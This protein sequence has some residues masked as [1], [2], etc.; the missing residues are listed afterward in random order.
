L[1]AIATTLLI[2][3]KIL[4]P[5]GA[6]GLLD[7]ARLNTRVSD[8]EDTLLTLV[9]APGGFGKTTLAQAWSEALAQRGN[10]IAWLSLDPD[11]DEPQ[12]FLHYAVHAFH[13]AHPDVGAASLAMFSESA[14]AQ[15]VHA[16]SLLINEIAGC[17]E[18]IFF[19]LDD[20]Q[21]IT[22]P[23]IH[24]LVS[25]M[26]RYAPSNLHL[27]ILSREDAPLATASLRVRNKLLEIDAAQLRF[28]AEETRLFFSRSNVTALSH[29]DTTRIHARTE[30]WPAALR[31][32]SLS[33]QETS[34]RAWPNP[35]TLTGVSRSIDGFLGELLA[36]LP[37]DLVDFMMQTSLPDQLSPELCVALAGGE[38]ARQQLAQLV[39]RQLL[40][41][42]DDEG[43]WFAYHQLIREHLRQGLQQ[44]GIDGMRDLHR[45][46][47]EW[48]WSHDMWSH[49][50]KHTL[51]AGASAQAF[52]WIEQCAMRLVKTG[53]LLTLLS[54][55]R[56]LQAHVVRQP[57]RLKL[58]LA[59]ARALATSGDEATRLL[60]SIEAEADSEELRSECKA[61]RSVLAAL[62]D[63]HQAAYVL[64]T[65][66]LCHS[67]PD[68]WIQ[69][70]AYN[71]LRFAHLKAGRWAD[72]YA[73]PSLPY[74]GEDGLRNPLCLV[75]GLALRGAGDLARGDLGSAEKHYLDAMRLGSAL[76]SASQV[77]TALPAGL[78][79]LV[80]YERNQLAEA[81]ALLAD[82]LDVLGTLGYLDCVMRAFQ[83]AARIAVRH[84]RIERAYA[85]LEQAENI[86]IG[87]RWHRLT[88]AM[89]LERLRLY[90]TEGRVTEAQAYLQRLRQLAATA[91]RT[92]ANPLIEVSQF[93]AL[94]EACFALGHYRYRDA[95]PGLE[96]LLEELLAVDNRFFAVRVGVILATAHLGLGDRAQ[97]ARVFHSALAIAAEGGMISSIL[98]QGQDVGC[99]LADA[100]ESLAE[101]NDTSALPAFAARVLH[102]WQA[103]YGK[104]PAKSSTVAPD[105]RNALSQRECGI[106]ELIADGNSNKEIARL[107]GI[108]P[109]TVKTH[110]KNIFI[111]LSVERRTQAVVRAEAY[112]LL[113]HRRR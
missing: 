48:Y 5:K 70:T 3:T 13:R 78:L 61:V 101:S 17:G 59:W 53:D 9:K 16:L 87:R 2:A 22:L 19:F 62:N 26:L 66:Y 111:K 80:L 50:V 90:L 49:A 112:G 113:K 56:Q 36:Q 54:W 40:T 45:R 32:M 94:G 102:D 37:P 42:L 73:M 10:L 25:F 106:L 31:V 104:V 79:S 41:A 57:T 63:D 97:A 83:V 1:N 81:D 91:P 108:G 60:G 109:E 43:Q 64:A 92:P 14:L 95:L 30:G 71:V 34:M 99:L 23:D 46:A 24:E 107:L 76:S 58:A 89:L 7:R 72:F 47:A 21:C 52:E 44:R 65:E 29:D 12:R 15:P 68:P 84:G 98:D 105:M 77:L 39:K 4:P 86:G 6:R 28:T 103:I 67:S 85:L 82:R 11:D 38:T 33:L 93:A 20:Y 51:E 96:E 55:E 110:L 18:E 8:I 100:R 27:I 88:A 35:G 69:H 75:Y 74:S